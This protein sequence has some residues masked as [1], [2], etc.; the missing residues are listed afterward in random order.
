MPLAEHTFPPQCT[1]L[2]PTRP[3]LKSVPTWNSW[4]KIRHLLTYFR[5]AGVSTIELDHHRVSWAMTALKSNK[6]YIPKVELALPIED[7]QR[8]VVAL[9][10]DRPGNIVRVSILIMF[11]AA[12]HQSEV[13][14]PTMSSF[15]NRKH[16]TRGDVKFHDQAVTIHIKHAK[17]MQ[18]V[19]ENKT[20]RLHVAHN[21]LLCVVTA[22]REIWAATPTISQN[23]PVLCFQHHDDQCW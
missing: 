20:V 11:Y 12:L 8:M 13:L 5:K 3:T 23:D 14:P 9:P 10:Q 16:L 7:L 6:E 18:S 21:P 1:T 15:D 17:N 19:Y 2:L 22:L 4:H